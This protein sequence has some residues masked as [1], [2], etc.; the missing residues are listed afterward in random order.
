MKRLTELKG[1][2]EA[3][4]EEKSALIKKAEEAKTQE[5]KDAFSKD[6]EA[7]TAAITKALKDYEDEGEMLKAKQILLNTHKNLETNYQGKTVGPDPEP[8]PAQKITSTRQSYAKDQYL[9]LGIVNKYTVGG[10]IALGGKESEEAK[11]VQPKAKTSDGKFTGGEVALPDVMRLAILGKPKMIK[12][13][14]AKALNSTDDASLIPEEFVPTLLELEQEP[15][16]LMDQVT[17]V[18]TRTGELTYP[19]LVQTDANE[20]GGIVADWINEGTTKPETEPTFDQVVITTHELAAYTEVTERFLSRSAIPI[21]PMLARLFRKRLR[22][23]IDDAIWSGSG[24]G[25][26]LG[27]INTTS[28]RTVARKTANQ[29]NPEDLDDLE[30]ALRWYHRGRGMY[31]MHDTALKFIVKLRDGENRP[32][33]RADPSAPHVRLLNGFNFDVQNRGPN[34]GNSGDIGFGLLSEYIMPMEEEI[35]MARSEHFKFQTNRIA[36]KVFAVVGGELVQPRSW[37]ILSGLGS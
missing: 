33:Y 18:P 34:L 10:M 14:L 6:I 27:I 25:R 31:V 32:L 16:T 7:K 13:A 5:E 15:A 29:V 21:E 37:V 4:L 19:R 17:Q 20:Y 23:F 24:T 8:E 35:T 11:A 12:S 30:F 9:K 26:P 36:F 2:A 22:D 1:K 3:L 28:I